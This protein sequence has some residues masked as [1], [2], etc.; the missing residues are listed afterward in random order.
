MK[1]LLPTGR[2]EQE[3]TYKTIL[4]INYDYTCLK[5]NNNSMKQ[6]QVK[7]HIF[8]VNKFDTHH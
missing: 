1:R 2:K 5:I 8:V 7:F 4:E 6:K 3:F